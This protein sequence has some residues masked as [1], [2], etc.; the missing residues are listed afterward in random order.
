M[1]LNA[2]RRAVNLAGMTFPEPRLIETNGVTLQVHEAGPEDGFPVLLL[3]G[4]PELA[5]SWK[6]VMPAVRSDLD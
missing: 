3:H 5:Y 6:N 2:P 4:W 1:R